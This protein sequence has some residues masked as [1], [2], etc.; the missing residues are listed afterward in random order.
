[1]GL[2]LQS[3]AGLTAK[4]TQGETMSRKRRIERDLRLGTS[5]VGPY[6][7]IFLNDE[8][9]ALVTEGARL[10]GTPLDTFLK[11]AAISAA[12]TL[13]RHYQAST[14]ETAARGFKDI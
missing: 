14:G 12:K 2:S 13:I 1:M 3:Y 10:T 6:Q 8:E 11:I 7:P 9:M 5:R 4:S